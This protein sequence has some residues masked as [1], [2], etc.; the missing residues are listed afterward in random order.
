MTDEELGR[1]EALAAAAT[2]GPWRVDH[3]VSPDLEGLYVGT[4]VPGENET[5]A[6]YQSVADS[7]AEDLSPDAVRRLHADL[8]FIAAARTA[9][10]ALVAEVRRLRQELAGRCATS[11]TF[12]RSLTDEEA[13]AL[14]KACEESKPSRQ[15]FVLLPDPDPDRVAELE[16]EVQRLRAS[17]FVFEEQVDEFRF[18]VEAPTHDELMR[19]K[20][21]LFG[22]QASPPP[23]SMDAPLP[24]VPEFVTLTPA[25]PGCQCSGCR[26]SA[27]PDVPVVVGG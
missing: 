1:L 25:G 26:G 9:V 15:S 27:L 4:D 5:I 2:P 6:Y 20:A 22:R 3:H 24:A 10:P 14:V 12:T 17:R 16:A 19:L 18:R 7:F 23:P 11:A 21:E 13:A 8:A